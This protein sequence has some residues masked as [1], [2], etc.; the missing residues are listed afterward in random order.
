MCHS[1][2]SII[3]GGD[4]RSTCAVLPNTEDASAGYGP[5]FVSTWDWALACCI[6]AM[7][8]ALSMFVLHV[9]RVAMGAKAGDPNA[10]WMTNLSICASFFFMVSF[11]LV[12]VYRNS[13]DPRKALTPYERVLFV[14]GTFDAGFFSL[15]IGFLLAGYSG[16]HYGS[17]VD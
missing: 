15:I 2:A 5:A 8:A 10:T 6:F 13:L 11:S 4:P 12:A 16:Y 17:S 7:L 3:G 9:R 1:S 14:G